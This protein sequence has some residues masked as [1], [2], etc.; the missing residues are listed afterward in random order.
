MSLIKYFGL[1]TLLLALSGSPCLAQQSDSGES[2]WKITLTEVGEDKDGIPESRQPRL[3]FRNGPVCM[4][5]DGL[6]EAD[7]RAAELKRAQ[8]QKILYGDT[9]N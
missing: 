9:A 4:C 3:K 6:S 8:T 1:F 7:I 5:A 2:R